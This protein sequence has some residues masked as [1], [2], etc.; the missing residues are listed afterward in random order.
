MIA[1][2]TTP[3]LAMEFLG[4][5]SVDGWPTAFMRARADWSSELGPDYQCGYGD[6]G[7]GNAVGWG[8]GTFT[9]SRPFR[10]FDAGYQAGW[11]LDRKG[12]AAGETFSGGVVNVGGAGPGTVWTSSWHMYSELGANNVGHGISTD[13]YAATYYAFQPSPGEQLYWAMT[14]TLTVTTEGRTYAG[15]WLNGLTY[16]NGGAGPT[17]TLIGQWLDP[18]TTTIIGSDQGGP[19]TYGYSG[20]IL[21]NFEL[22]THLHDDAGLAGAGRMDLYVNIMFSNQPVPEPASSA[23]LLGGISLIAAR[24]RKGKARG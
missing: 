23:V 22:G 10:T 16:R 4:M 24:L 18:G 13:S 6:D 5:E 7:L 21:P 9:S 8:E 19:V 20:M 14:W 2:A 3:A 11:D 15:S 17:R 1:G 12:G